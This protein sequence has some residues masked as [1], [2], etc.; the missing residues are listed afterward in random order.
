[1]SLERRKIVGRNGKINMKGN[2][3]EGEGGEK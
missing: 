3:K 1:M 2:L